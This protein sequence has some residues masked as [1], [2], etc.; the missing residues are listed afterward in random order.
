[1][2][3]RAAPLYRRNNTAT[4]IELNPPGVG[5]TIEVPPGMWARAD[6]LTGADPKVRRSFSNPKSLRHLDPT[7]W[8]DIEGVDVI[9]LGHESPHAPTPGHMAGHFE[10]AAFSVV[11]PEVF[12]PSDE[13][14]RDAHVPSTSGD[15]E[16]WAMAPPG[17]LGDGW[18]T[19]VDPVTPEAPDVDTTKT[20]LVVTHYERLDHTIPCLRSIAEGLVGK[21]GEVIVANDGG[22]HRGWADA[23]LADELAELLEDV[24]WTLLKRQERM[25]YLRNVNDAINTA[26]SNPNCE[27][28]IIINSDVRVGRRFLERMAQAQASTGASLVNPLC[29]EQGGISLPMAGQR[30]R[31]GGIRATPQGLNWRDI[32][33]SVKWLKPQHPPAVTSVGQCL[34]ITRTAWSDH[35]P[36]NEVYGEGYGEECEL[37]AHVVGAGGKAVIADN[38]YVWHASHGSTPNATDKEAA[39]VKLFKERNGKVYEAHRHDV[40]Q[41][42]GRVS[43][44]LRWLEMS[45]LPHLPVHFVGVDIGPWGGAY[46]L[47]QIVDRLNRYPINAQLGHLRAKEHPYSVETAPVRFP[48]ELDQPRRF[49][50]LTGIQGGGVLVATQFSSGTLAKRILESNPGL[51]PLAFWQDVEHRFKDPKTG[52]TLPQSFVD[53]YIQIPNRIFNSP[54]VRDEARKDFSA[55]IDGGFIPVGVD[56]LMFRPGDHPLEGEKKLK[57]VAMWRPQTPRRGHELIRQVYERLGDKVELHLFGWDGDGT[58]PAAIRHGVLEQPAV[59]RLLRGMDVLLEASGFQGFG[60]PGA[61]AMASH[62][63][64]VSTDTGGV[65]AYADR[66]TAVICPHDADKL[67]AS[68]LELDADRAELARLKLVG[69]EAIQ[70]IDWDVVAAKWVLYLYDL[71]RREGDGRYGES[72]RVALEMA[73]GVLRHRSSSPA[74]TIS[75]Q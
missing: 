36:F 54:W 75:K 35:G 22:P 60:L 53:D 6:L 33:E 46:C 28:V 11:K 25:G 65:W 12:I 73:H 55:A 37:W 18:M 26:F 24:P 34:L 31:Y 13:Y 57:V 56:T 67:A 15:G 17:E 59:A 4:T 69:G 47:L 38:V 72:M 23:Q 68:I 52:A 14:R 48:G 1:M 21:P 63:A 41:W 50:E 62:T 8:Q 58:P 45:R 44:V 43:H 74:E 64:L 20:T 5:Y 2:K 40:A 3:L 10:R 16:F 49:R 30:R 70:Q 27:Q 39:G 71:W 61:E 29:N 51:V 19:R 32:D 9:R 42:S 66:D 7:G